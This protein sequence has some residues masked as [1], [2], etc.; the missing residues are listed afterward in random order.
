MITRQESR[1]SSPK[2]TGPNVPVENL[3]AVKP[4]HGDQPASAS[5]ENRGTHDR[6]FVFAES[7]IK[8]I[9]I[10]RVSV[11][12]STGTGLIPVKLAGARIR[13]ADSDQRSSSESE[14]QNTHHAPPRPNSRV[15]LTENESLCLPEGPK[16]EYH[17]VRN[18]L[19]PV[20]RSFSVRSASERL[21]ENPLQS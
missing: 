21:P 6:M 7:Q 13:F 2:A 10:K 4:N 1:R 5:Q 12:S 20:V 14:I 15:F 9:L 19:F 16:T 3:R 11:L 17:S 8:K 18:H